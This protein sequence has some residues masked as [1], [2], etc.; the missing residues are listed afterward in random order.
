MRIGR[1]ALAVFEYGLLAVFCFLGFTAGYSAKLFLYVAFFAWPL[2]LFQLL[3]Q[4]VT[5]GLWYGLRRLMR[6]KNEPGPPPRQVLRRTGW[7]RWA[8]Y[9]PFAFFLAGMAFRYVE[10]GKFFG[11]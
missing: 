4:G 3:F 7:N 10:T 8:W 2:F 1:V 11:I 9:S 5:T 6:D